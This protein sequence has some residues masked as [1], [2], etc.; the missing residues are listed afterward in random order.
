MF[1]FFPKG[2]F[3]RGGGSKTDGKIGEGG[4]G[5]L[6]AFGGFVVFG[7]FAVGGRRLKGGGSGY[8]GITGLT[9]RFLRLFGFFL[10]TLRSTD[11]GLCS[12]GRFTKFFGSVRTGRVR[13]L[14]STWA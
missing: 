10:T 7:G 3:G 9:C 11:A 2:T 8:Y 1:G 13:W 5:G 4:S 6:A 14:G 12:F